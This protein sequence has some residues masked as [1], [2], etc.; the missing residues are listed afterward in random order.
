MAV[1][2]AGRDV[3]A[4]LSD[5]EIHVCNHGPCGRTAQHPRETGA[6]IRDESPP[7]KGDG[8]ANFRGIVHGDAT[9]RASGAQRHR[10]GN[11]IRRAL[12][13]AI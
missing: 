10:F 13:R 11:R 5:A 12:R 2:R 7:R 4:A 3:R 9:C 8:K 6:P 1:V